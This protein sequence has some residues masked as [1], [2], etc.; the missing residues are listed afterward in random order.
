[1]PQYLI[2]G[3]VFGLVSIMDDGI[4]TAMGAHAANNIFGSIFITYK[5]D[6]LQG[7]AL[8]EQQS[9]NPVKEIFILGIISVIF[10]AILKH[11]YKWNFTILNKNLS[12][13]Y[14]SFKIKETLI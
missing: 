13:R 11:K 2:F 14:Y 7:N 6:I 4:E 1:M 9:I 5:A 8:L 12:L 3:L 10:I